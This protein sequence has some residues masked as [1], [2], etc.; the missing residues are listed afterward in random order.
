[1]TVIYLALLQF[2]GITY[3]LVSILLAL[4]FLFLQLSL[5]TAFALAL[6]VFTSSVLATLLTFAVYLV[7]NFSQDLVNIG[8]IS[9]N[10]GFE[11]VTQTLYLT[12]PDLMLL[13]E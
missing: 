7:G 13:M 3:S 2:Q 10:P 11:H 12:L 8:R 4:V 6:G 5:I 1:M 9:K